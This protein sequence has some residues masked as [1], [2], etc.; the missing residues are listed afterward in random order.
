MTGRRLDPE[1]AEYVLDDYLRQRLWTRD[2]VTE[3]ELDVLVD[4]L[5]HLRVRHPFR[6]RGERVGWQA[7]A[8]EDG[9]EPR[10]R[11]STGPIR[12]PY[13]SDRL[14]WARD[15]GWIIV[16]EG[17]SDATTVISAFDTVP[18]V[19]MPGTGGF[20]TDWVGAF[21]GLSVFVLGD[22]DTC[23]AAFRTA[24]ENRISSVAHVT[25]VMVPEPFSDVTEWLVQLGDPDVFAERFDEA[26]EHAVGSAHAR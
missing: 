6:L 25:Q 5:G 23:G 9:V 13:E 8:V 24:V 15:A 14:G 3:L 4:R 21:I 12:C 18:V 20:K 10:W 16:T 19:G 26:C 17:V 7:R 22:N 1:Q 11:S 2:I